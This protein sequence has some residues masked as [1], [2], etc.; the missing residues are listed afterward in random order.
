MSKK[1]LKMIEKTEMY[2]HERM[3]NTYPTEGVPGVDK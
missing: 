1:E 3:I 2:E